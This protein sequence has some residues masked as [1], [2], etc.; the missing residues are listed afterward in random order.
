PPRSTDLP[1]PNSFPKIPEAK[2]GCQAA[3]TRGEKLSFTKSKGY[4]RPALPMETKPIDG[5]KICPARAAWRR[6]SKYALGKIRLPLESAVI[7]N[8]PLS[9]TGGMLASQ[10]KPQVKVKVEPSRQLS[11]A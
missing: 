4:F 2:L 3:E 8:F 10:A 11:C 6:C 7:M 5:L 1:L 9:S